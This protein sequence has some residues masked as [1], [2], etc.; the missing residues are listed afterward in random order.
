MAGNREYVAV[1]V[2]NCLEDALP[3]SAPPEELRA[4]SLG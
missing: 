3:A 1:A 4:S 2:K